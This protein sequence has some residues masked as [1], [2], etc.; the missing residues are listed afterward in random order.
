MESVPKN[1]QINMRSS[2]LSPLGQYR[3]EHIPVS[4]GKRERVAR[5]K[6]QQARQSGEAAPPPPELTDFVDVGLANITRNLQASARVGHSQSHTRCEKKRDRDEKLDVNYTAIF[7]ARSGQPNALHSH[8]PQMIAVATESGGVKDPI[9][10]V[11]FSKSCE[12]RLSECLGIPRASIIAIRSGAPR[13][14][15]LIDFVRSHVP[16]VEVAWLKEAEE[17]HHLATKINALEVPIGA[18]RQKREAT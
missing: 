11:G 2:L 17:A 1:Q 6:A 16:A 14:Q 7:A 18:K 15:A 4:K 13:S 12:D 8:L 10:L 3:R 9:R 5:K